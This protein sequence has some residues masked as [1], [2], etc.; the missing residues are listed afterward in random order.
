MIPKYLTSAIVVVVTIIWAS[1]FVLQFVIPEY[2][3]DPVLHAVFGSIVG[4]ALALSRKDNNGGGKHSRNHD[5]GGE[6]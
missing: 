2:K 4:S 5:Q 3:P 6:S 1:N